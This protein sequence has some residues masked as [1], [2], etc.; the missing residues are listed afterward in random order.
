MRTAVGRKDKKKTPRNQLG[1]GEERA[2]ARSG[3][4][5]GNRWEGGQEEDGV[6]VFGGLGQ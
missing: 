3:V 5:V 6:Q 1:G 4:G 2:P